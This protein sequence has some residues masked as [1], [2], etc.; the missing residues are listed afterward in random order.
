MFKLQVEKLGPGLIRKEKHNN[1]DII[2]PIAI[3]PNVIELSYYSNTLVTHF[4]LESVIAIA[5]EAIDKSSGNVIHQELVENV[6]E[7]CDILQ[8]EFLFSKPCQS[9]EHVITS[10]VDDLVYRKQ[11]FLVVSYLFLDMLIMFF[12][13]TCF[14]L[15]E[16]VFKIISH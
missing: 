14:K 10:C 8:Y 9:L 16:N 15:V 12:D 3:L 1:E 5:I 7:L 11:I 6:Q 2:K 4:V 13:K